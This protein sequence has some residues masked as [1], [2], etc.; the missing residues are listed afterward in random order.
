MSLRRHLVGLLALLILASLTASWSAVYLLHQ[1]S[2]A[3]AEQSVRA[4]ARTEQVRSDVAELL[5]EMRDPVDDTRR[6]E[7]WRRAA[8]IET[9]IDQILERLN[10][11][12]PS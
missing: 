11:E 9:K 4:E 12:N 8:R 3:R 1:A 7:L 2:E 5:N 10:E 6:S